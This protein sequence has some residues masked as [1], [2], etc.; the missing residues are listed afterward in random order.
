MSIYSEIILD[1]YQTPRNF[2][3]V[4]NYTHI[5]QVANPLCGD[6][7]E[8]TAKLKDNKIVDIKFQGVGCA[9]SIASASML[10]SLVLKKDILSLKK[11]DKDFIIKMLGVSL[12]A[13]RVKCALLP[14]EALKKLFFSYER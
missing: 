7:L 9:I 8:M 1:H 2:G 6:R 11:I 3:R 4:K 5:V 12:G 14:L 10:T 13:N